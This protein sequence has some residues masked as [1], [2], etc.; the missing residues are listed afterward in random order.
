MDKLGTSIMSIVQRLSIV[1]RGNVYRQGMKVLFVFRV[2]IIRGSSAYY[3]SRLWYIYHKHR[4][5]HR[6]IYF[7]QN[8][9]RG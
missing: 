5:A 2:S 4:A 9:G 6:D 3:P 1:Q 7:G 8:I